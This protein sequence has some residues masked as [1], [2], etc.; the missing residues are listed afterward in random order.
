MQ[1]HQLNVKDELT[2]EEAQ[3]FAGRDLLVTPLT[4]DE[5]A[6][7]QAALAGAQGTLFRL[8][9]LISEWDAANEGG[10]DEETEAG[11]ALS[12]ADISATLGALTIVRGIL[13]RSKFIPALPEGIVQ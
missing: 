6:Q 1:N 7:L 2:P 8:H 9:E 10:V 4:A 11:A 12:S 5:Y 3:D 13:A